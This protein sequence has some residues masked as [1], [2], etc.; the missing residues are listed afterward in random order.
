MLCVYAPADHGT[1]KADV[2]VDSVP[3]VPTAAMTWYSDD[4]HQTPPTSVQDKLTD[5]LDPVQVAPSGE[6]VVVGSVVSVLTTKD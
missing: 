2:Y 4:K 1:A 3:H 5:G 6:I